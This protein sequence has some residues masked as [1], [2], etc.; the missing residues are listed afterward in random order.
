MTWPADRV[1]VRRESDLLE[2]RFRA[3]R[4]AQAI[5]CDRYEVVAVETAA[6]ELA[7]NLLRHARGGYVRLQTVANAAGQ[8]LGLRVEACNGPQAGPPR[9]PAQLPTTGLGL[10][11]AGCGRLMDGVEVRRDS[12]SWQVIAV[13]RLGPATP[14]WGARTEA[15]NLSG[16]LRVTAHARP[17]RAGVCAD[18]W[19]VHE[20][21]ERLFILVG[22]VLGRGMEAARLADRLRARA[23]HTL[24]ARGRLDV[25]AWVLELHQELTGTRGACVLAVTVDPGAQRVCWAGAGNVRGRLWHRGAPE[26]VPLRVPPGIL[27]WRARPGQS[28]ALEVQEPARL[29]LITDG[30][31]EAALFEEPRDA[32]ALV[33]KFA[34]GGDDAT[35]VVVE[36]T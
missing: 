31:D 12:G 10:G 29:A 23:L 16:R 28:G 5:G 34:V 21:G 19:L 36:W 3:R 6:S 17:A 25:G 4:L 13:K 14:P 24:M 22:D 26:G 30:V 18:T 15:V 20:V 7:T 35:A 27:G 1:E 33:E 2:V 11:L 8:L 9:C 32:A